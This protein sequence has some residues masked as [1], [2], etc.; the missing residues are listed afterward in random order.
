MTTEVTFRDAYDTLKKHAE[1]LR[2]R[3][4]PNIDDLLKIV[5][6]SVEA[7]QVCQQRIDAVDKALQD[8]LGRQTEIEKPAPQ[9]DADDM[10]DDIP[11]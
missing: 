8:A 6:E 10:D 2:N 3:Q 5:E 4:E 7:F 9:E 1:T 11:F